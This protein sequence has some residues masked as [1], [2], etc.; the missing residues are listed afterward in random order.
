[1]RSCSSWEPVVAQICGVTVSL[2]FHINLF[3]D[4]GHPSL[5]QAT[6]VRKDLATRT[7]N[8]A[9]Q[10]TTLLE[11]GFAIIYQ[12]SSVLFRFVLKKAIVLQISLKIL[13]R[14]KEIE[15]FQV[16]HEH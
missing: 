16:L 5:K 7:L 13:F 10:K 3:S 6:S 9:L 4:V 2:D 12:Q 1:M 14:N 11:H 15:L 8:L